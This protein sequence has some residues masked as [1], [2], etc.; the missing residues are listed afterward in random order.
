MQSSWGN[1]DDAAG[2]DDVGEDDH[3]GGKGDH[4]GGYDDHDYFPGESFS[5]SEWLRV[6]G[7]RTRKP[8]RILVIKEWACAIIIKLYLQYYHCIIS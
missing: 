3:N 8:K 7:R 1:Y 4:D 2:D 6:F 5:T